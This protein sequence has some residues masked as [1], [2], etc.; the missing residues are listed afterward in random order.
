MAVNIH[1]VIEVAL[2]LHVT[3]LAFTTLNVVHIYI[4]MY[5]VL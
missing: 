5:Y 2:I 1:I 3:S 4:Y